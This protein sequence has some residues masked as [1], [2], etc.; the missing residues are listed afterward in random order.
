MA[1]EEE[2]EEIQEEG[3]RGSKKRLIIAVAAFLL[4]LGGGGALYYFHHKNNRD[5]EAAHHRLT[6][7]EMEKMIKNHPIV[8]LKPF[9]VNLTVPPGGTPQYL[10]IQ[11]ALKLDRKETTKEVDYRLPEIKSAILILLGAQSLPDLQSTGGKL[12][13]KDAIRHRINA[14]LDSGKVTEV[15]I[16]EF[17]IQ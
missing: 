15:Y 10:K 12:A 1:E 8:D 13:L 14:R 17:V 5:D 16:T 3:N 6:P 7:K 2:D 11:L 4:L 9:I